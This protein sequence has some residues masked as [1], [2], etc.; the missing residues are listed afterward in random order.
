M[1]EGD[2][3]AL[4]ALDLAV[5]DDASVPLIYS[6]GADGTVRAWSPGAEPPASP[7]RARSCPVTALAAAASDAGPV[8]AVG[9]ADGLVEC[10]SLD[11]GAV[12]VFRPGPPV[13]SLAVTSSG[14]LLVGTDETLVCLR[15]S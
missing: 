14:L 10:H 7:V 12:R 5:S 13:R 11:D 9:W 6:G 2:V 8:L 3:T 15:P 4:A 1:H